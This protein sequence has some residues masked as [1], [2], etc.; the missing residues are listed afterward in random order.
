MGHKKKVFNSGDS[1][2]VCRHVNRGKQ[3]LDRNFAVHPRQRC[4]GQLVPRGFADVIH[5]GANS[6]RSRAP[7]LRSSFDTAFST[8]RT[9]GGGWVAKQAMNPMQRENILE[10]SGKITVG[11]AVPYCLEEIDE[12]SDFRLLPPQSIDRASSWLAAISVTRLP[13]SVPC[14]C[15]R[16]CGSDR[17]P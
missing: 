7:P 3:L 2:Q 4:I 12:S 1:V 5:A 15:L 11:R 10:R 16:A 8:G 17:L 9:S 13:S 6:Q 14:S